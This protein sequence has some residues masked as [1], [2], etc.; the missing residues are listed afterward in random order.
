LCVENY[1]YQVFERRQK[2]IKTTFELSQD[3]MYQENRKFSARFFIGGF[4]INSGRNSGF[5]FTRGFLGLSARGFADYRYDDYY[6]GRNETKGFA[7]QQISTNTEGG[8]KFTLP[9]GGGTVSL[10]V[11]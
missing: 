3:Y 4:P 9:E 10:I 8:L 5:G 11:C 2:F 6:F 7:S 1:R